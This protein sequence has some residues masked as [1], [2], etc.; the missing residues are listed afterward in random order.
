M[1]ELLLDF[2]TSIISYFASFGYWGIGVMMAIE[3]C[4]IPITSVI[5][6][7][8]GGYLVSTG[9]LQFFPAALAGT[10]GGTVGS[11]ISYYVGLFGGR[12]FLLRYGKYLGLTEKRLE[13]AENWLSRYGDIAVFIS[14]LVPSIRNLISLPVGAARLR[15]IPF[16]I[17]T[18]L[19]SLIWALI[20]T[21]C[22]FILGENWEMVRAWVQGIGI[23]LLLVTVLPL[24]GWLFL[25]KWKNQVV[26]NDC[27]Q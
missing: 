24:L 15:I 19:G 25:R 22:G 1:E 11:V 18:F 14:Q 21:Y 16:T 6:L 12:P 20:L 17:Y 27:R 7:P 4:N 23:L 26:R 10:I 5:I 8:F 3:S 9:Q 2:A 13:I